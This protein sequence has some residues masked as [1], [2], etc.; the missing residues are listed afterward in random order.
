MGVEESKSE[1]GEGMEKDEWG[2]GYMGRI[3]GNTVE[4]DT[5][6]DLVS[7]EVKKALPD[8][9]RVAVTA[10]TLQEL[11]ASAVR[12]ELEDMLPRM[13]RRARVIGLRPLLHPSPLP[14][15]VVIVTSPLSQYIRA[16][17]SSVITAASREALDDIS[18]EA[19]DHHERVRATLSEELAD[20]RVDVTGVKDDYLAEFT[21]E[22][23][24]VYEKKKE[25][26][27]QEIKAM[28]ATV[29]AEVDR[30]EEEMIGKIEKMKTAAKV[31]M[32]L[33]YDFSCRQFSRGKQKK[34]GLDL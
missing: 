25:K 27:T 33:R 3:G 1:Q 31:E 30:Y 29:V 19:T 23:D 24:E 2:G 10:D 26:F 15:P 14:A 8:A 9:L 34:W 32:Q 28:K 12:N 4:Q 22:C 7:F 13:I 5:L 17:V 11:V 18:N 21:H 16:H 20:R 6:Q